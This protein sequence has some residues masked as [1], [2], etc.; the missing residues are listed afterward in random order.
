MLEAAAR[1][2]RSKPGDSA[3]RFAGACESLWGPGSGADALQP[4]V[5]DGKAFVDGG[6]GRR[7]EG[8]PLCRDARARAPGL[9]ATPQR[10]P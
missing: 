7:P 4:N 6:V 8:W 1:K 10:W 3:S 5:C 2:E 9:R